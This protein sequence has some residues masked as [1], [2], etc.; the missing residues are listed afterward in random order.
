MLDFVLP[1]ASTPI[2]IV[3]RNL[4]F[5]IKFREFKLERDIA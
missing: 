2:G 3:T 5:S 1:R 4:I